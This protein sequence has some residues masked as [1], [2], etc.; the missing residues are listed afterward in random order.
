MENR[1]LGELFDKRTYSVP[2]EQ[3]GYSWKEKNIKDFICDLC[4]AHEEKKDHQFGLIVT[5]QSDLK[6]H[7]AQIIDGQQRI[8]TAMLFLISAR[9]FF[10]KH[11]KNSLANKHFR[12][13]SKI[14]CVDISGKC[15]NPRLT[16][17]K[18]NNELFQKILDEPTFKTPSLPNSAL[19]VHNDMEKSEF[20]D[21]SNVLLLS[22]LARLNT[23]FKQLAKDAKDP[24]NFDKAYGYV[25][26]LLKRFIVIHTNHTEIY[27]MFELINNRGVKLSPA[28]HVK[29]YLLSQIEQNTKDEKI[30]EKYDIKWK[31]ITNNVTNETGSNYD[32]GKFLNHYLIVTK[33]PRPPS[34]PH[35]RELHG[36]FRKLVEEV[37]IP[38]AMIIDEILKWSVSFEQIRM[39]DQ[40]HF[41]NHNIT[42]YLKKINNLRVVY[43]YPVILGGY[44][45]YWENDN[46]ESFNALVSLCCKYHL[47]TRIA[48]IGK[49]LVNTKYGKN[50]Y[51]ILK[52]IFDNQNLANII[53]RK[54]VVGTHYSP[55]DELNLKLK[56]EDIT[57]SQLTIALLEEIEYSGMEKHSRDDTTLEHIMPDDPKR[58]ENDILKHKPK[59]EKAED[60][61]AFFHKKYYA[62]LGNQT[63]LSKDNNAAASNKPLDEKLIFY[64]KEPKY[65]ITNELIGTTIWDAKTIEDRQKKLATKLID[66][67]NIVNIRKELESIA[68]RNSPPT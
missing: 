13:I 22:A 37:K 25:D 9:N 35:L 64:D 16:L 41:K 68:P 36:G 21:K 26:T 15:K 32:L 28:D 4:K 50:L 27:K 7:P 45:T 48:T 55:D 63:L 58:W 57:D 2:P 33:F 8:T 24:L 53:E 56:T 44:K 3:R 29:A 47:K 51:E 11:Q 40:K 59:G 18:L 62:S 67:L 17:S 31:R 5:Q 12:N 49:T 54:M 23:K 39:A 38:P 1:T 14:L 52:L 34:V 6:T 10:S 46:F 66:E 43:A 30:M 60:Y 20:G 65:R 19:R 42:H 61:I